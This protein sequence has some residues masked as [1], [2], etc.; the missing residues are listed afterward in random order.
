MAQLLGALGRRVDGDVRQMRTVAGRSFANAAPE[1]AAE[2]HQSGFRA[3]FV[4][5]NPA[6]NNQVRHFVAYFVVGMVAANTVA[7]DI[8]VMT[9]LAALE[10]QN[11]LQD[12]ALGVVAAELGIDVGRSP[13]LLKELE[14]RVLASTCR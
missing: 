4:D 13:A 10:E 8:G 7:G 14:S 11:Q 6:S 5:P 3:P 1:G 12:Y 2:F 9:Q